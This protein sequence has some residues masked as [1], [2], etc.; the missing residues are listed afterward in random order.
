MRQ[1][2]VLH[3]EDDVRP[4]HDPHAEVDVQPSHDP[5]AEAGAQPRYVPQAEAGAQPRYVPQAEAGAQ[6]RYVPH[7]EAGAQPRH[8]PQAE[9]GAQP[10]YVPNVEA[11]VG[12]QS[13]HV[14][15][16][17]DPLPIH[18]PLFSLGVIN[19]RSY[20]RNSG[21]INNYILKH[22]FD[23]IVLTETWL[24]EVDWVWLSGYDFI[25]VPRPAQRG[26]G[27]AVLCK[28][29]YRMT[30]N[31]E[32]KSEKSFECMSVKMAAANYTFRIIAI[33]RVP[34]SRNNMLSKLDFIEDFRALLEHEKTQPD[35]LLITGDFNIHWNKPLD[36]EPREF[37]KLIDEFGFKQHV[38]GPTHEKG[39]T[40][41]FLLSRRKD[42][43]VHS[44]SVGQE[45]VSDH[46]ALHVELTCGKV[47]NKSI[48]LQTN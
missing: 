40:L 31:S 2:H 26:G 17:N 16:S 27:V 44:C 23:C 5:H 21:S 45:F 14:Q 4:R 15:H 3:A 10:R 30:Q 32:I 1:P 33:Y 19:C 9:A 18:L 29:Q 6:P 12:L 28:T 20:K 13:Q 7:A 36:T 8:V 37:A 35:K 41:D 43:I 42:G 38:S 39:N 22:N 48:Q 25:S 34:P 46:K 47:A 11:D 24:K